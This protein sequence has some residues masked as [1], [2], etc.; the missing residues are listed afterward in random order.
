MFFLLC[1]LKDIYH[2]DQNVG[3]LKWECSHFLASKG[4]IIQSN[5]PSAPKKFSPKT[6]CIDCIEIL[7]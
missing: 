3:K 4:P 5:L 2:M 6:R 1:M 7:Y